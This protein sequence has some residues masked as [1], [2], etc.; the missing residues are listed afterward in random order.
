M[1]PWPSV[2][3]SPWSIDGIT[4]PV[5]LNVFRGSLAELRA[6]AGR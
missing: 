1:W 2:L 3:L 6:L 4:G 5:D